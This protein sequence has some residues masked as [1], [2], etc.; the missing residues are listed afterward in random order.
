[1]FFA[2]LR[3]IF[4]SSRDH[5]TGPEHRDRRVAPLAMCAPVSKGGPKRRAQAGAMGKTALYCNAII[6]CFSSK[7][8]VPPTDP[9]PVPRRLVKTPAAVHPLPGGEGYDSR[10]VAALPRCVTMNPHGGAKLPWV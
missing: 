5:F 8:I 7:N 10:L 4:W 1:V 6:S 3:E 9:S 2:P